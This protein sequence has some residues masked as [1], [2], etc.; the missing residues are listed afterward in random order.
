M[1]NEHFGCGHL[2]GNFNMKVTSIDHVQLAMPSGGI[3]SAR[4]FYGRLLGLREL[5]KPP[6]RGQPS[7]S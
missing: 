1:A 2:G 5:P 7:V 6:E 4:S 3:E